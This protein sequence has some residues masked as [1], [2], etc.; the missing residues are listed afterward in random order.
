MGASHP[1]CVS[2]TCATTLTYTSIDIHI[3]THAQISRQTYTYVALCLASC[4]DPQEHFA[5]VAGE[6]RNEWSCANQHLRKRMARPAAQM[7][8]LL[9]EEMRS[10]K[11]KSC[12][13]SAVHVEHGFQQLFYQAS[14]QDMS[15]TGHR[16]WTKRTHAQGIRTNRFVSFV[17]KQQR[18]TTIP[19][20]FRGPATSHMKLRDIQTRM[21]IKC[22]YFSQL[23]VFFCQCVFD[24]RPEHPN[25]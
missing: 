20:K 21:S 24:L 3:H 12:A 11:K 23:V 13:T 22:S 17:R 18:T 5:G 1:S 9:Q 25:I 10:K 19:M 6:C 4:E 16:Q 15:P 14:C 2:S 7:Q 8:T